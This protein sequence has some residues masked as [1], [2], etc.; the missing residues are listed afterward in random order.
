MTHPAD[1]LDVDVAAAFVL[2]AHRNGRYWDERAVRVRPE[3][4]SAG[5]DD[6]Q[7]I[8]D[9]LCEDEDADPDVAPD[10]Q[11]ETGLTPAADAALSSWLVRRAY[12][13]REQLKL[14]PVEPDGSIA[15]WR[16]IQC[17]PEDVR[18]ALGVHWSWDPHFCEGAQAFWTP[19]A[20]D[21]EVPV[22]LF[23]AMAPVD[24]VDWP[25]TLLC[26]MDYLCG[27]D[28]RELR[29]KDGAPLR[30]VEMHVDAN[31]VAIPDALRKD[32]TA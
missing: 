28:E 9:M 27:D 31:P 5:S 6:L 25:V 12:Y 29:L 18:P 14:I 10:R 23:V 20:F 1:L 21:E 11:P 15:V 3:L 19:H 17:R 30:L 26:A 24:S 8:L 32:V 4:R 13:A 7:R 22:V 16:E 2:D